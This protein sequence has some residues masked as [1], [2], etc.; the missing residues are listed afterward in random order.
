LNWIRSKG[1]NNVPIP[2]LCEIEETGIFIQTSQKDTRAFSK[3]DIN[4]TLVNFLREMHD[5]TKICV[6]FE[7]TDYY[8]LLQGYS[9]VLT[10]YPEDNTRLAQQIESIL[11]DYEGKVVEFSAY[12]GD[13]TPW[14]TFYNPDGSF[15][16]FDFEYAVKTYPPM[17]DMYHWYVSDCIYRLH[18]DAE[19]IYQKYK[20]CNLHKYDNKADENMKLYLASQIIF[21]L[22]RENGDLKGDVLK[23]MVTWG[24]L[25]EYF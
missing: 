11:G 8:K 6:L 7:N 17:L 15:H 9:N 23:N 1:I 13:F 4:D 14:N 3:V 10:Y 5:K 25:L 24:K 2:L 21:Y 18:L 16:V 12:H 22:R 20:K 19:E